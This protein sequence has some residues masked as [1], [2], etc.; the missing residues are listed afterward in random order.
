M[1]GPKID[2]SAIRDANGEVLSQ[3]G[4]VGLEGLPLVDLKNILDIDTD[5]YHGPTKFQI[6]KEV[7]KN[8]VFP[9]H[10]ELAMYE[11]NNWERKSSKGVDISWSTRFQMGDDN[12]IEQELTNFVN[13]HPYPHNINQG[14]TEDQYWHGINRYQIRVR[15]EM[16]KHLY[17]ALGMSKEH[18]EYGEPIFPLAFNGAKPVGHILTE[19]MKISPD[20]L[21]TAQIKR[22]PLKDGRLAIAAGG[23]QLPK[24][25]HE[26]RKV[27][28]INADDCQATWATVLMNQKI[29]EL[30]GAKVGGQFFTAVVGTMHPIRET[31]NQ[32]KVPTHVSVSSICTTLAPNAYLLDDYGNMMVGDMGMI[33]NMKRPGGSLPH[34]DWGQG[35]PAHQQYQ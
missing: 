6:F 5:A 31:L 4:P 16:H 33:L 13:E 11:P 35:Y 10:D 30:A 22:I 27:F 18:P 1:T 19:D 29:L 14:E 26:G 21:L 25:V 34:S 7:K 3:L 9:F 15:N 24:A 32:A 12:P 20:N 2:M 23:I 17:K 28:M 8:G